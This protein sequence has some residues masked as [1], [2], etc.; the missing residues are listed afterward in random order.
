MAEYLINSGDFDIIVLPAQRVYYLL[1]GTGAA[2]QLV[3]DFLEGRALRTDGLQARWFKYRPDEVWHGMDG[4]EHRLGDD[5]DEATLVNYFVLK[6]HN[7]GSLLA[8]RDSD[9]RKLKIFKSARL[10]EIDEVGT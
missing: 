7:F 9:T 10:P 8:V 3:G 5:L 1:D 4:G 6:K 2:R